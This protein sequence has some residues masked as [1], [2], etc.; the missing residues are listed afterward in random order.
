MITVRKVGAFTA[1]IETVDLLTDEVT[2]T[3]RENCSYWG[4]YRDGRLIDTA[5]SKTVANRRAK[6]YEQEGAAA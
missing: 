5:L 6:A 2:V 1:G 4:I 3:N